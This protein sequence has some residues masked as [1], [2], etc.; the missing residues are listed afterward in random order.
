VTK[1]VPGSITLNNVDDAQLVK[2]IE[3]KGKASGAIGFNPQAIMSV[4]QPVQAG[5][6]PSGIMAYS[7]VILTWNTMDAFNAVI[8]LLQQ[9]AQKK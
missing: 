2:I 1:M 6:A 4:P 9:L 5:R 8:D 3:T 7:N